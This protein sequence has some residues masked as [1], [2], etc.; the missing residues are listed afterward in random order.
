M[1]RDKIFAFD[2]VDQRVRGIEASGWA[3][4][5]IAAERVDAFER[6]ALRRL[7]PAARVFQYEFANFAL[8]ER[9]WVPNAASDKTIPRCDVQIKAG[10]GCLLCT[11]VEKARAGPGFVGGFVVGKA[12]VAMQ[13]KQAA[14]NGLWVAA[15][16]RT[17]LSECG[18]HRF[19]QRQKRVPHQRFILRFARNK[20]FAGIVF[21]QIAQKLQRCWS[22]MRI[23]H[24]LGQTYSGT[25]C[26][27]VAVYGFDYHCGVFGQHIGVHAVA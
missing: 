26:G 10:R 17:N 27:G 8:G 12:R 19:N 9:F 14:A 5:C 15:K 7:H 21:C 6:R 2:I 18:L 13:P 23:A 24:Y 22:E 4:E 3:H 11:F 1:C 20:P 16:V 25:L